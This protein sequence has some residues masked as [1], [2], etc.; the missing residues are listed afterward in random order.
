[1]WTEDCVHRDS[2]IQIPITGIRKSKPMVL[3]GTF[4]RIFLNNSC[5]RIFKNGIIKNEYSTL[6]QKELK[7]KK[8]K[9]CLPSKWKKEKLCKQL[10]TNFG[11]LICRSIKWIY[12]EIAFE[13][14]INVERRKMAQLKTIHGFYQHRVP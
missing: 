2:S 7:K 1:L 9:N 4:C 6:Q 12:D 11:G 5:A 14:E 10:E 3:Y 8:R 13:K